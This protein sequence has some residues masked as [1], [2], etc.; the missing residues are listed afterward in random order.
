MTWKETIKEHLKGWNITEDLS[1]N[2]T[3]GVHEKLLSMRPNLNL[4]LLLVFD[5]SLPKLTCGFCW[6]STVE[7]PKLLGTQGFAVVVHIT[8]KPNK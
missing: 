4:W 6:V 8:L 5:Y 3:M 1:L 2:G 7:C